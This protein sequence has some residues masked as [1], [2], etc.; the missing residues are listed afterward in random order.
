MN[1]KMFC[2]QCEQTAA[3]TGC[4]GD[5]GICGKKSETAKL[6]DKL[7]GALITYGTILSHDHSKITEKGKALII[8]GLFTTVTNVNFNNKTISKL[9]EK[10]EKEIKQCAEGCQLCKTLFSNH[11]I[12]DT[13]LIWKS[14]DNISSLK[15]FLLFGIRGTAAFA[16]HAWVLG[17][18]DDEMNN[19]FIKALKSLGENLSVNQ[20]IALILECGKI[21]MRSM[22]LLDKAN[23]ETFGKPLPTEV[24]MRVEKGPFI[25]VSGHDLK[26]LYELLEQTKNT[27]INIYS[28]GEMLPAHG[29]PA[30]KAFPHFKGHFGTAW[31]NQQ[32]EFDFLPAPILFTTNCLMPPK[33]SYADRVFTT[34]VVSYPELK[35]IDFKPFAEV[36]EESYKDKNLK[37]KYTQIQ[38]RNK[39]FSPIIKKALDLGGYERDTEQFGINGGDTLSTGYGHDTVLSVADNL[40]EALEKGTIKHIFLVGGCDG[41]K[42]GRN[43]YTDFVK[44]TPKDSLILTLACGKFR[45]NDLE[46]GTI[47]GLPRLMDMGQ[48]NDAYSAIKVAQVLANH[49]NCSI[50]ELPISFVLSWYEQKAVA[51]LLTLLYLGIK[52]IYLGP[53]LPAFISKNVLA[54]LVDNFNIHP[55][56]TPKKDLEQMLD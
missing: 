35:H 19:F 48:C 31:Q 23:T 11:K 6:Q 3:G 5:I 34:G 20:Y 46:L 33:S 9:T 49:Y 13:E 25:V 10:I 47:E 51:I 22:A 50:N 45:F 41:A 54:Y 7:T 12:F 37:I 21:N 42:P 40:I 32:K 53:S 30:L 36:T 14:K 17:Y 52:D 15:S 18:I 55:T 28:H 39:D 43:Y 44:L 56:S 29:Y 26:D 4:I 27:G 1:N 38:T 16:Y 24:T 8:E 2:Y